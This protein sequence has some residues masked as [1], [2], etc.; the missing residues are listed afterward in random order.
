MA[1]IRAISLHQPWA[2]YIANGHKTIK[3]RK[4]GTTCS[5]IFIICSTKKPEIEGFP[6]GMALAVVEL[7]GCRQMRKED[8]RAAMDAYRPGRW[9]WLL[10]NI[11]K[12]EPPFAVSGRQ[13]IFTIEISEEND[14][15]ICRC[16]WTGTVDDQDALGT[17][18]GCCP[19]CGNEDLEFL[20]ELRK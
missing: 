4:W 12:I 6:C 8:E 16:G 20:S 7:Y 18:C 5:G 19:D 13:G 3:T 9:S 14:R 17:E 10:R 11:R 15:L 1:R 2:S